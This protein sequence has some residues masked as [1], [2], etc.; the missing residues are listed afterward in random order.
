MPEFWTRIALQSLLPALP[1]FIVLII[2]I[3]V[4]ILQW[5]KSPRRSIFAIIAFV[6]LPLGLILETVWNLFG[7]ELFKYTLIQ[8]R[9]RDI[10]RII[11]PAF[12]NFL[13]TLGLIFVLLAIF[14]KSKTK[15]PADQAVEKLPENQ[16]SLEDKPE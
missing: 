5:K 2:G 4:A 16:D 15:L 6:L 7:T 11:I 10:L 14:G 3:V 13:K 9:F 12:S 8:L 1:T